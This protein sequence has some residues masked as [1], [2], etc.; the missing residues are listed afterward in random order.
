MYGSAKER[1]LTEFIIHSITYLYKIYN[2]DNFD[3]MPNMKMS[4][5]MQP[6]S[7]PSKFSEVLLLL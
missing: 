3:I 5:V 1:Q 6:L 2:Y 7:S 4:N